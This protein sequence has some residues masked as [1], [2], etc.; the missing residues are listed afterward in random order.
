MIWDERVKG[1]RLRV[2]KYKATW[3]YFR[4]Y[5]HHGQRGV[6]T[7]T[8]GEWPAMSTAAARKA[9]QVEAGRIAAGRIEPSARSAVRFEQ[10]F[11]DYL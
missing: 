11:A 7:K 1:L 9:A 3:S 4:Q 8:L 6:V 10:A 2:G 5:S